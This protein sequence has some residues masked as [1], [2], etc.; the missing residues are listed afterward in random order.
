MF[1]SLF[2]FYSLIF[3]HSGKA[4]LA[5][6]FK[7]LLSRDSS[8]NF[9]PSTLRPSILRPKLFSRCSAFV[10]VMCFFS[11]RLVKPNENSP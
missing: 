10:K 2:L 11:L 7:T 9:N 8:M 6:A 1:C 3:S 5:M 4:G